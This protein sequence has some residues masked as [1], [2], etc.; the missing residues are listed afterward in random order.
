MFNLEEELKN[1]PDSPGVYIMH[2]SDDEI[3][4]VGK[5][6]ILKNRVRQ[7]FHSSRNHSPKVLAMVSNIK[8]FEYIVTDSEIEALVLECNLIK[9]HKPKYNIL[10]KD[11]KHYPYIKVSIN[12]EYPKVYMTRTLKNDG[13]KY[14]GPYSGMQT[15]RTTLEMIQKIF[16]PP[17]C[18]RKFPEGI[19][20]GRPCLNYHINNCFAP[21]ISG[22]ITR[23]EY[24]KV[25]FDIC[26]FLSGSHD[27][28][29][30]ELHAEMMIASK[31]ME[32]EKAAAVRDKIE[33]VKRFSEKQKITN[34]DRQTDVDIIASARWNDKA[35]IE[36]FFVRKGKIF[37]HRSFCISDTAQIADEDLYA[38]FIKQFYMDNTEI[39]KEILTEFQPSDLDVISRWLSGTKRSKVT[40][41]TPARGDKRKLIQMVHKNAEISCDNYRITSLNFSA[42]KNKALVE[43][44]KKLNLSQ[45]PKR[46]ES[47]DIS[48]I[49][50]ADNVASMVV[51]LDGKPSKKDYRYFKIKSFEGANDYLAMQEVIYRRFR[52]ALEEQEKVDSGEISLDECKFLPLPDLILLDGGKGHLSS[53]KEILNAIDADVA[54]YGMVKDNKH[55]TRALV[56]EDGEVEISLLESVFK[57]VTQ[58]QDEVHRSAIGYHRKLRNK[59]LEKSQLDEING[60]GKTRKTKLL[61]HFKTI[62][63]IKNADID[64][65]LQVVD[66]KTAQNI[67]DFFRKQ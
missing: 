61:S 31:N 29:L 15:V 10:L 12:Q 41:S 62:E 57:F 44:T 34:A 50:G 24:R 53:V 60:V 51:F 42:S 27:K 40:V 45:V 35:F 20:K 49:S 19:G 17:T 54:V 48:N 47:Y 58:I 5:A 46:I 7:Y 6:K 36:V 8:Y 26:S 67:Y 3:I 16:K 30:E 4:Y 59:N 11:D 56:S 21:C 14:F 66:S 37:G 55:R 25:F 28:L 13:G 22:N 32:F 18:K 43:L 63:N 52:H 65:L 64:E 38:D 9:K 39:P 33:A 23:D 2:G 1:L